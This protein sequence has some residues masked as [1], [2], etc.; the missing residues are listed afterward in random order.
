MSVQ[1][2][3]K[4]HCIF[5][6][7]QTVSA[8]HSVLEKRNTSSGGLSNDDEVS[9][10]DNLNT[11]S[12]SGESEAQGAMDSLRTSYLSGYSPYIYN[13]FVCIRRYSYKLL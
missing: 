2:K 11:R 7:T 6:S 12:P 8:N 4:L 3:V 9:K 5:S 1:T 13:R 10:E